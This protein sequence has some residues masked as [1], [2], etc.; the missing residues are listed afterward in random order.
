MVLETWAM[1]SCTGRDLVLPYCTSPKIAPIKQMPMPRNINVEP[2]MP[3][4]PSNLTCVRSGMGMLASLAKH[5]IEPPNKATKRT[6]QNP[7][8][9]FF[10]LFKSAGLFPNKPPDCQPFF[11]IFITF[12]R[13][14]FRRDRL[15]RFYK[16]VSNRCLVRDCSGM[17]LKNSKPPIQ[18]DAC[19]GGS[20]TSCQ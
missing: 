11:A 16:L 17:I 18:A 13:K 1:L 19:D 6:A 20:A 2:W 9:F 15:H 8:L 4:K 7:S 10:I 3:P 14:S 5:P 12:Q